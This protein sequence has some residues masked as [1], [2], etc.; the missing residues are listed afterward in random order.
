M[1]VLDETWDRPICEFC[2]DKIAYGEYKK[3]RLGTCVDELKDFE[4]FHN[5]K[6]FNCGKNDHILFYTSLN[7]IYCGNCNS[8]YEID[9]GGEAFNLYQSDFLKPYV[10]EIY[11]RLK[12]YEKFQEKPLEKIPQDI[13]DAANLVSDYMKRLGKTKWILGGIC[14]IEFTK[15]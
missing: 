7:R 6:C 4:I 14:D 15:Q 3:H 5:T 13:I 1:S 9:A 11:R 12:C 10:S 2:G 8:Q